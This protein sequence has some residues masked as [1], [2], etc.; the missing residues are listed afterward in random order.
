MPSRA[1]T[2]VPTQSL[3][4]AC[5]PRLRRAGGSRIFG[6]CGVV[7]W[8][9][10][11]DRQKKNSMA[12]SVSVAFGELKSECLSLCSVLQT[13]LSKDILNVR[14][15]VFTKIQGFSTKATV[16][17]IVSA[18]RSSTLIC[19]STCVRFPTMRFEAYFLHKRIRQHIFKN[20]EDLAISPESFK[21]TT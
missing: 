12:T 3:Q 4:I 8:S 2:R 18:Q 9:R 21:S 17:K 10:S 19:M 1:A 13:D 7:G 14:T 20:W 11:D 16:V 15:E 6:R 5:R